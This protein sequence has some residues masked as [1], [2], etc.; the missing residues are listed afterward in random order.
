MCGTKPILEF[1][2]MYFSMKKPFDHLNTMNN[3]LNTHHL[4]NIK[5]IHSLNVFKRTVYK[6]IKY[7]IYNVYMADPKIVGTKFEEKKIYG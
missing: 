6:S 1:S 5:F 3:I 4:F 7:N 2:T